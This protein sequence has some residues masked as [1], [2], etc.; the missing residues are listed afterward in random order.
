MLRL[1]KKKKVEILSHLWLNSPDL[2]S[3]ITSDGE[4]VFIKKLISNLNLWDKRN[5]KN[6]QQSK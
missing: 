1:E 4:W 2:S 6:N 5:N 3:T